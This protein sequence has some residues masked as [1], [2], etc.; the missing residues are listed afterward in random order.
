MQEDMVFIIASVLTAHIPDL[1]NRFIG[2]QKLILDKSALHRLR[3]WR[4]S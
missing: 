2:N 3:S 1:L 4:Y